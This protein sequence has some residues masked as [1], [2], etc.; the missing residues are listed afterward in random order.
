MLRGAPIQAKRFVIAAEIDGG[1][2]AQYRK[3]SGVCT[4]KAA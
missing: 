1:F 4:L 2:S 3:K